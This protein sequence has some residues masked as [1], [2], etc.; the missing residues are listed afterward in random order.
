MNEA[1]P[2]IL[3]PGMGADA[4]MFSALRGGLPGIVT[5]AWITPRPHES[6]VEYARRFA[7]TIDPG[8]PCFI[9]GASLGGVMAL[10]VAA[11]LPNV[12]ACFVIGSIRSASS[13]PWRVKIL[14]PITPLVGILPRLSP[15]IVRLL[16]R[17]LRPPTRGVLMQ[18]TEADP[19]F[20]RW[21]SAA[22]L[23]WQPSP[24][25][26]N[27]RVHH[28]HGERDR[29]FPVRMTEADHIVPGAG[30]LISITHPQAVVEFLRV[31]ME[32]IQ[33]ETST[34]G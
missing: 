28:I 3:L 25:T 7:G 2:L 34:A 26:R 27:V 9:G 31:S 20:L 14:G 8:R 23:R 19:Q 21:A 5:P 16:G 18:L 12:R 1:E 33:Q 4:R 11:V 17:W 13:R 15:L 10:E 32:M 30:H 6:L 29:V 22:I 24:E